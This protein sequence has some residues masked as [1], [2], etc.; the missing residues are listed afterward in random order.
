MNKMTEFM[1]SEIETFLKNITPDDSSFENLEEVDPISPLEYGIGYYFHIEKEKWEIIGA[2]FDY[3]PIY[4]TEREDETEIGFSFLSGMIYD[5]I[6]VDILQ[7]ENYF[8]P[9]HEEG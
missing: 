1:E 5:D 4:D 2:Q 8:F 9:L 3:A 6:S 7:K